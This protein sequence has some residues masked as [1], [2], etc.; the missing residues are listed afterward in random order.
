MSTGRF[1]LVDKLVDA[2]KQAIKLFFW[3][4]QRCQL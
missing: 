4:C 1:R 2:E 3:F